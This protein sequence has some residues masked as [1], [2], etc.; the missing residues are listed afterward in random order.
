MHQNLNL[1]QIGAPPG[2]FIICG[3]NVAN[4]AVRA[5]RVCRTPASHWEVSAPLHTFRNLAAEF[6]INSGPIAAP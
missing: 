3:R 6:S 2:D 5:K 4:C 1:R